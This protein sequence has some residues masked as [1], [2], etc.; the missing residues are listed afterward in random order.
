MKS[1][2]EKSRSS[3]HVKAIV[4]EVEVPGAS[5]ENCKTKRNV[6]QRKQKGERYSRLLCRRLSGPQVG[7]NLESM[8]RLPHYL[9]ATSP[10]V[11]NSLYVEELHRIWRSDKE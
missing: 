11:G 9:A 6:W 4:L 1:K 5:N 7:R 10:V 8:A 2:A 3:Q